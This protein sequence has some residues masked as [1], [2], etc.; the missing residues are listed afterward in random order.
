MLS[1]KRRLSNGIPKDSYMADSVFKDE[2]DRR[3]ERYVGERGRVL[4]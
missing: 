4:G 2:H 1:R 3:V